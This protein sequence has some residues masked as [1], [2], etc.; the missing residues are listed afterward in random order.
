MLSGFYLTFIILLSFVLG[1]DHLLRLVMFI[2]CGASPHWT[3]LRSR[4]V[5]ARRQFRIKILHFPERLPEHRT[6]NVFCCKGWFEL[7]SNGDTKFDMRRAVLQCGLTDNS[8]LHG[9]KVP[10]CYIHC[11]TKFQLDWWLFRLV[12]VT[13]ML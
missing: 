13:V 11:K 9:F 5:D 4:T 10:E 7:Q 1:D 2:G 8:S 12:C 3:R 6:S